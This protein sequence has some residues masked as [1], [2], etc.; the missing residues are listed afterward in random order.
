MILAAACGKGEEEAADSREWMAVADGG[1]GGVRQEPVWDD[2][3]NIK[4]W[5]IG[6]AYLL[7]RRFF[8]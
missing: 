7:L 4:S 1:G 2:T 3:K 8:S 5:M 6:A